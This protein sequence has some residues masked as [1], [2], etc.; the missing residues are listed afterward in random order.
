MLFK[1]NLSRNEQAVKVMPSNN[2]RELK[3]FQN[4]RNMMQE[5]KDVLKSN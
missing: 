4:T 3:S 2:T 1:G 5:R